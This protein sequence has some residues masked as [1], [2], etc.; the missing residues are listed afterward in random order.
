MQFVSHQ[1]SVS[2][3]NCQNRDAEISLKWNKYTI[4]AKNNSFIRQSAPGFMVSLSKYYKRAALVPF[5]TT[6]IT[7]IV[8]ALLHDGSGYK[9]EWFTDDGFGL[10]IAMLVFLS[11]ILSI[12][13][14]TLFLNSYPLIAGNVLFSFLAWVLPAFLLIG[15]TLNG[16][17]RSWN[18]SAPGERNVMLDSFFIFVCSI[19]FITLLLSYLQFRIAYKKI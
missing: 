17:I 15:F 14:L 2:L 7:G 16:E 13:S 1:S 19:H 11:A 6:F 18:A 5:V 10:A 8:F 9:S 3:I 12:L 4:S